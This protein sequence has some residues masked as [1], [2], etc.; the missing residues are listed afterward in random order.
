MHQSI[1]ANLP[2]SCPLGTRENIRVFISDTEN[3]KIQVGKSNGTERS[4]TES[5][6]RHPGASTP[7]R[8][9]YTGMYHSTGYAFCLSDSGTWYKN[10][11]FSLKR[12]YFS[13]GLTLEQG[14]YF[15]ES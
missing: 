4:S 15:P 14:R 3:S 5:H 10:H 12:V 8:G 11:P 9:L 2:T 6:T 7:I 1:P 13:V